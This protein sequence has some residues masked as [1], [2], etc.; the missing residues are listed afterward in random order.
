MSKLIR[1]YI[2]ILIACIILLGLNACTPAENSTDEAKSIQS[3]VI[4]I[5]K[6]GHAVLDI[7]TADFTDHGYE[8]GDIVCVSFDSHEFNMPFFDGYYSTPGTEML[9]GMAADENIAICINYGDF[10]NETGIEIGD[11][12]EISMAEK[13]GMLSFYELSALKYSDN[14]ADYSDDVTFANFRAVTSGAIGDGKLYRSAS[15][16]NNEHGRASYANA[17]IADAGVATVLNLADSEEDI[18][19][20]CKAED[21][22]S[23]YYRALYESGNVIVLDLNVNFYS[24]EFNTTLIEGL[25]FLAQNDPPYSIH[26]TEGKDRAGFTTMLLEALMGAELQEIIDDYMLSFYNYYGIDKENEPERYETVLN[27]NLLTMLYHITGTDS[28]E[29]LAQADL[30]SAATNYLLT[31]GMAESDIL[32]LKD[33]LR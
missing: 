20:Y 11:C 4:E 29:E 32:A 12:V 21:F 6:Y 33:K 16:I 23:E 19:E 2:S 25:C 10:S 3:T 14:R 28:A 8:F 31:H 24:D 15:P 7:T 5:E 22:D 17:L 27:T 13:A 26:C 18:A 9:R 1:K 30:E